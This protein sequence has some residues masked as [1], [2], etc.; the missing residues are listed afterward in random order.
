MKGNKLLI[1]EKK[2]TGSHYTPPALAEF[3][4]LQILQNRP[5]ERGSR[6]VILDPAVGDGELLLSLLSNLSL[7]QRIEVKVL[8]FDTDRRAVQVAAERLSTA[9]PEVRCDLKVENFLTIAYEYSN[10]GISHGTDFEPVDIVIA[11]PPYA[12]SY[13]HL[14]LPTNREV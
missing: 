12:V 1:N 13:T 6:I 14:T 8:G 7:E 2:K 5:T 9:F 11:N 3:V 4:S 10:Q